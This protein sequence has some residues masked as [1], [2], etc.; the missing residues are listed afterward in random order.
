MALALLA[1]WLAAAGRTLGVRLRTGQVGPDWTAERI[2]LTA[3]ALTA[4]A[5]GFQSAIDW[6]WFIPG[7]TVA[8]LAAAG[9]VAGRGPLAPVGEAEPPR[10]ARGRADATR[11]A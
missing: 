7:P 10:A 9:F 3:L 2:A 11:C 6:T 4:V 8:A 5:Y 1:A